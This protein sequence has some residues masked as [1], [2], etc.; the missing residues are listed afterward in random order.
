LTAIIS[1]NSPKTNQKS[2]SPL[3]A[4]TSIYGRDHEIIP[5]LKNAAAK[6]NLKS[7]S[8]LMGS[9]S[10]TSTKFESP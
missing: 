5:S 9:P 3:A 7:N 4:A 10:L 2:R 8:H 6:I 1:Q